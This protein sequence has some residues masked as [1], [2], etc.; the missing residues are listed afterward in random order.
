MLPEVD[1]AYARSMGGSIVTED[2]AR[3]VGPGFV[4]ESAELAALRAESSSMPRAGMTLG[5]E[6]GALLAWLVRL[7][8]AR[9][10][11]DIGVFTG[12]SALAVARALPPEGRIIACDVSEDFTSIGRRHWEKAGVADKIDLRIAPAKDTLDALLSSGEAGRFDF[13]FI[14]AD[15][16][17]YDAYY[18]RCLQLVRRD[19]LIVLDNMLW[20]GAVATSGEKDADTSALHALNQKVRRDA[21][22]DAC[23]LTVGDGLFTLRVR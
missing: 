7:V 3:Y 4:D 21:R 11:L 15:K 16:P 1:I 20:S 9:R 12:Y 19:G 13:A 8:G 23:L 2:I 10:T 5:V 6:T 22:V 17:G 14:D 18:E